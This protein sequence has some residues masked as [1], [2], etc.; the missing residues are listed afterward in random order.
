[1]IDKTDNLKQVKRFENQTDDHTSSWN[2]IRSTVFMGH[3]PL[4]IAVLCLISEKHKGINEDERNGEND[5]HPPSCSLVEA[6]ELQRRYCVSYHQEVVHCYPSTE[7]AA[8]DAVK[9]LIETLMNT[10]DLTKD[11]NKHIKVILF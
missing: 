7:Q 9:Y 3:L 11:Q 1:M 8:V 2:K 10:A 4:S 6:K 5:C